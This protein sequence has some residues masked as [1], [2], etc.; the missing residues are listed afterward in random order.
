MAVAPKIISQAN[1]NSRSLLTL[2]KFIGQAGFGVK[3]KTDDGAIGANSRNAKIISLADPARGGVFPA[4]PIGE[5]PLVDST[6]VAWIK[7]TNGLSP[8]STKASA[9]GLGSSR[10]K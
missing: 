5:I 6:E 4:P 3:Q 2:G 10:Y 8:A 7:A 1:A 9:E